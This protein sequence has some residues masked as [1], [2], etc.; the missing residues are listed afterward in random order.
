MKITIAN[1]PDDLTEL[2]VQRWFSAD[3]RDALKPTMGQELIEFQLDLCQRFDG[4]CVII[5][6]R[7]TGHITPTQNVQDCMWH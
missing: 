1:H 7:P 4:A 3:D 5:I 2:R 6:A